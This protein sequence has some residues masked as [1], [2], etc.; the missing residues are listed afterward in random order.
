MPEILPS[1]RLFTG[2]SAIP[3]IRATAAHVSIF[4]S[5]TL[6]KPVN[7]VCGPS[8]KMHN[9]SMIRYQRIVAS[10]SHAECAAGKTLIS[11]SARHHRNG[12]TTAAATACGASKRK[13]TSSSEDVAI[14]G[15]A[16]VG[17]CS[18]T[19]TICLP[20]VASDTTLGFVLCRAGD[21]G[22]RVSCRDSHRIN[23]CVCATRRSAE[24]PNF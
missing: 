1:P 22:R 12:S 5:R 3:S 2:S 11:V 23:N 18:V 4:K 7:L 14:D 21:F 8:T 15:L 13:C 24:A 19:D 6:L 9:P 10:I 16:A 20:I 17:L